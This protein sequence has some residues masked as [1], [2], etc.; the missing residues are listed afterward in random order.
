M[1]NLSDF[2][3]LERVSLPLLGD[4][5][6]SGL[7]LM[8][9]L[10]SSGKTQFL[11]DIC[12]RLRGEIRDPVVAREIAL[13]KVQFE[14][15]LSC[16]ER[17]GYIERYTDTGNNRQ[18]RPKATYVGSGEPSALTQEFQAEQWHQSYLNSEESLGS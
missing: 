1:K 9:G 18:I 10:N 11:R 16:L 2:K 7:I 3:P 12:A 6:C 4:L 8:V 14:P 17:E 5:D 13:R 15:F